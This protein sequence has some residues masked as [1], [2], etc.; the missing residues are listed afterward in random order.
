[1]KVAVDTNVLLRAAARDD[2]RQARSA[3]HLLRSADQIV[4]PLVALCEFVWVMR[5]GYG[6]PAP[7]VANSIRSLVNSA[8]TVVDRSSVQAGLQMLDA[9]GDFAD[10]VIAHQGVWLGADE[11]VSFDKQAVKLLK[12]QGKRARLLS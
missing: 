9:G 4:I 7:E 6:R 8:K 12:A 2:L 5:S 1:M 3:A 11:F 10:G